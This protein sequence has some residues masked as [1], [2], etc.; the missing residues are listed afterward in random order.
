MYSECLGR[1]TIE[2]D[3]PFVPTIGV[4]RLRN[5]AHAADSE[6]NKYRCLN[7]RISA[8]RASIYPTQNW[9]SL[10]DNNSHLQIG[11][12]LYMP[13]AGRRVRSSVSALKNQ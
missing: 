8:G 3:M 6:G 12:R 5:Y 13:Q 4:G 10:S 11:N 2:G 7:A 1:G 9:P